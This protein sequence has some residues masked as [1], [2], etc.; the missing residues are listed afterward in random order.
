MHSATKQDKVQIHKPDEFPF[1]EMK[2]SWP[3][4]G[5]LW[6]GVYIKKR[7]QFKYVGKDSTHK[8]WYA[9]RDPVK[10]PPTSNKN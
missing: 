1:L 8:P 9:P 6:F 7:R 3:P 4:E 2:T 5:D 10:R